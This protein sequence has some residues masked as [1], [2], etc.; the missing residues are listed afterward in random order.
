MV[1]SDEGGGVVRV[2]D[3]FEGAARW[4]TTRQV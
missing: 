1:M 4:W 2:E 3:I